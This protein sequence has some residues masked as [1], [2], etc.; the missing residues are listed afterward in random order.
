MTITESAVRSTTSCR[1]SSVLSSELTI[2][3]RRGAALPCGSPPTRYCWPR[4]AARSRAPG[5]RGLSRSTS[6]AT[7]GWCSNPMS[8]C[9]E[10]SAGSPRSTRFPSTALTDEKRKRDGA[11]GRACT[12]RSTPCPTTA[13]DTG[14]CG[15]S[16]RRPRAASAPYAQPDIF[17]S[18]LGTIPELPSVD[19][20]VQLDMDAAMPARE[21]LPG[22]G[23]ALELRV[24][25]TAGLLHLDWWFD[26]R[27]LQPS[28]VETLAEHFPVALT[29]LT[30]EAIASADAGRRNDLGL[31]RI[32]A[33]RLVVAG[34]CLGRV[35]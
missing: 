33:C 7:D 25:R 23:H 16:T 9:I 2:A 35:R 27:R 34:R 13:S 12:D 15:T 6:R 4:W 14:C 22:L 31:R 3:S 17:F 29:E 18:Y 19:G 10:P 11:V 26:I 21:M 32:R 28:E 5:V 30:Q 20:P 24:Y 1:L 8:I